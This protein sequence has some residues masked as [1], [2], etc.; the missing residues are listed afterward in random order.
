MIQAVVMFS[1]IDSSQRRTATWIHHYCGLQVGKLSS[2]SSSRV[3]SNRDRQ[4]PTEN[5]PCRSCFET[6]ANTPK[7]K[8]PL[9]IK[10]AVAE[11]QD[12]QENEVL[13]CLIEV[14]V[15]ALITGKLVSLG[16]T[17]SGKFLQLVA[18]SQSTEDK[19]D[20]VH[21]LRDKLQ[22]DVLFLS[23]TF[24]AS[25]DTLKLHS[26]SNED[27]A[28]SRWPMW[29]GD[30]GPFQSQEPFRA[31]GNSR[32]LL[33]GQSRRRNLLDYNSSWKQSD[34]TDVLV[35]IVDRALNTGYQTICRENGTTPPVSWIH[36]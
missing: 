22:L 3:S 35:S 31:S 11:L 19:E 13:E 5:N 21:E 17:K 12:L 20:G 18:T 2:L 36:G 23:E 10:T 25:P 14:T 15:Q 26:S 24:R 30:M 9:E 28:Q 27:Y 32:A 4:L 29:M 16:F 34:G 6:T 33:Q 1:S 8:P 7:P